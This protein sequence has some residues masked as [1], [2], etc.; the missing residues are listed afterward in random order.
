[1]RNLEVFRF[2]AFG[3][4]ISSRHK[5][6]ATGGTECGVNKEISQPKHLFLRKV[7]MPMRTITLAASIVAFSFSSCQKLKD[8]LR[9]NEL[10]IP[11]GGPVASTDYSLESSGC[12][13]DFSNAKEDS[14]YIISDGT[15]L[16][17][18]ILCSG[19][20]TPPSIDFDQYSLVL[21]HGQTNSNGI[22]S[23]AKSFERFGIQEYRFNIDILLNDTATSQSWHIA[24]LVPKLPQNT[25]IELNIYAVYEGIIPVAD[26]FPI[27]GNGCNVD[28]V[29]I[30]QDSVYIINSQGEWDTLISCQN[31]NTPLAVD[32]DFDQYSLL[33]VWGMVPEHFTNITKEMRQL[34]R[35]EYTLSVEIYLGGQASPRP[36]TLFL[37]TRKLN[38]GSNNVELD[39]SVI[40]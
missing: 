19:N 1:M 33:F 28:L 38:K 23:I 40:I 5:H 22:T 27:F 30:K 26:F 11:K 10:D 12:V 21:V 3:L 39:V 25:P 37:L 15:E 6:S 2:A 16:L 14:T 34:S 18:F 35:N 4:P 8:N 31:D 13:W 17:N 24:M 29:N 32:V 7:T 20:S 9:I 36:W